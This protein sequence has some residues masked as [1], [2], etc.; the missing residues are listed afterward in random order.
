MSVHTSSLPV[1]SCF[2]EAKLSDIQQI[3]NS[4]CGLRWD[5]T[6]YHDGGLD[7]DYCK[8][9]LVIERYFPPSRPMI[10]QGF[11]F[12]GPVL[13]KNLFEGQTLYGNKMAKFAG[14]A[15]VSN[16]VC[17]RGLHHFFKFVEAVPTKWFRLFTPSTPKPS[18][19]EEGDFRKLFEQPY[20]EYCEKISSRPEYPSQAQDAA[21]Y[22]SLQEQIAN[23][24]STEKI[25]DTIF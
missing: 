21:K 16:A 4:P 13:A 24:L 6:V 18:H 11:S 8:P 25:S 17:E 9:T 22:Q 19:L 3:I 15:V 5:V 23:T 10:V 20:I 7:P 1:S 12:D 2:F 14:Y